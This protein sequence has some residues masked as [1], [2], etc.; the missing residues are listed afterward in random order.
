MVSAESGL[1]CVIIIIIRIADVIEKI[2][3]LF[4]EVLGAAIG[5][6]PV[7]LRPDITKISVE[8]FQESQSSSLLCHIP[9]INTTLQWESPHSGRHHL[10]WVSR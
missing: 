1:L 8:D 7:A 6:V 2:C 9:P 5:L 3:E 10:P 4:A